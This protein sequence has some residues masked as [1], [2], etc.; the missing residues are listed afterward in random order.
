MAAL[1]GLKQQTGSSVQ[2][3]PEGPSE[4]FPEG[5]EGPGQAAPGHLLLQARA[6][7]FGMRI[8]QLHDVARLECRLNSMANIP[9]RHAGRV[10]GR[11]DS[12]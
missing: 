10:T 6:G 8:H 2:A 4:L 11:C 5:T 7:L 1:L 9:S 12:P 3:L